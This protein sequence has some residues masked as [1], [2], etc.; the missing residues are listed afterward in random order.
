MKK[1][2]YLEYQRQLALQRMAEQEREVA[3]MAGGYM[4]H[5]SLPPGGPGMYNMYN[6]PPHAYQHQH[7]H[8]PH[9][10]LMSQAG[11]GVAP[12]GMV[13]AGLP[14]YPG[15][16]P[17]QP[18]HADMQQHHQQQQQQQQQL[19]PQQAPPPGP[20]QQHQQP[21]QPAVTTVTSPNHFNMAGMASALPQ[22]YMM[23]PPQHQQ[24][25]H[26]HQQQMFSQGQ[27]GQPMM[28]PPMQ[29]QHQPPPPQHQMPQPGAP[30]ES[31]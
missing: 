21:I 10:G 25:Q 28:Q 15:Y 24:P 14:G 5:P 20:E 7:Q 31:L 29:Q 11:G 8:Q 2:E 19:P 12:P 16:P 26:L 9:P 23:S 4:Q 18:P 17:H 3:S 6:L 22:Q 27:P 13:P 1:A 30:A